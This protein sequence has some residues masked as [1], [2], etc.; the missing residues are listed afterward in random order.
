M[1]SFA[2]AWDTLVDLMRDHFAPK[3]AKAIATITSVSYDAAGRAVSAT[4]T[5]SGGANEVVDLSLGQ[6]IATGDRVLL[7]GPA[8]PIGRR[9]TIERTL[10]TS[11]TLTGPTPGR[12]MPTVVV[13]G[14][15]TWIETPTTGGY[16]SMAAIRY[17][18]IRRAY[19]LRAQAIPTMRARYRLASNA[20]FAMAPAVTHWPYDYTVTGGYV[21]TTLA[22][23]CT[24]GATTISLTPSATPTL[25]DD[26]PVSL[27]DTAAAEKVFVLVDD[28]IISG[29]YHADGSLTGC[30]RGVE[31]V[32][33]LGT[34]AAHLAGAAVL[35]LS[36]D[37]YLPPLVPGQDYEA[38]LQPVD[39]FSTYG[40]FVPVGTTLT[41]TSANIVTAPANVASANM[42]VEIIADNY[43][44]KWKRVTTDADG[45]GIED[46]P[47][48]QIRRLDKGSTP[49]S[50]PANA[51]WTGATKL[52]TAS[53][54]T[55][56][57]VTNP[58]VLWPI[59]Q[60]SGA[61]FGIRAVR[62]STPDNT[63]S[64]TITWK[65][66]TTPPPRPTLANITVTPLTEGYQVDIDSD[67]PALAD[68]GFDTFWYIEADD[69]TGTNATNV[70]IT[71]ATTITKYRTPFVTRYIQVVAVDKAGNYNALDNSYWQ[72]VTPGLPP[73][74][75]PANGS[76]E[77]ED[78]NS[79]VGSRYWSFYDRLAGTG[80]IGTTYGTSTTQGLWGSRAAWFIV[81]AGTYT[82]GTGVQAYIYQ[83]IWVPGYAGSGVNLTVHY[84]VKAS[85]AHTV[86]IPVIAEFATDA[87]AQ[88][89]ASGG[90]APL[91]FIDSSWNGTVPL[92]TS[93]Q[94][95]TATL[96]LSTSANY[97]ALG[98]G[99]SP[100][101][102]SNT[103]ASDLTIYFDGFEIEGVS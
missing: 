15:R 89:P 96:A 63:Y 5:T 44:I 47:L 88:T 51:D 70:A 11:N 67:E 61:W 27:D 50:D 4:A 41:W 75:Y 48:Y 20:A 43:E 65:S 21:R 83:T 34:A 18:A 87:R 81:P 22:S 32:G 102:P 37:Y 69:A 62:R 33:S 57:L 94:K 90:F 71:H 46:Q 77:V 23:G 66:D 9:W 30:T 6:A 12:P 19:D 98:I 91:S 8:D 42:A 2:S 80:P 60:G 39:Q 82:Y 55:E 45:N 84:Y 26:I 56:E 13:R 58:Y 85:A 52:T 14:V 68:R 38:Q 73:G 97:V 3:D 93:W 29:W 17:D 59:Q 103:F 35:L 95:V 7:R 100:V 53:T 40:P 72:A 31:S 92:T 76:F 1:V 10:N 99:F 54:A 74:P 86:T 64:S 24:A 49:S 78:S 79:N 101:S 28:E 36:A 25:S 16:R